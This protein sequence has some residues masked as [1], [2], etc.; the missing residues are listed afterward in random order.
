MPQL[1]DIRVGQDWRVEHHGF[2]DE[3]P[4]FSD[5]VCMN[6]TEDL[7]QLQRGA[8]IIDVGFYRGRYRV[9]HVRDVD[10]E[11][12]IRAQDCAS[13]QDVLRVIWKWTTD[14]G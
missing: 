6:L 5:G 13:R 2:F 3:E 14:A 7:L 8:E 11:N 12:P 4:I 1:L 9:T 10:W